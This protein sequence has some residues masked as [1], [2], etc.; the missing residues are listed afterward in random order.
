MGH[1]RSK[2]D[3]IVQ[4]GRHWTVAGAGVAGL[5]RRDPPNQ[6]V[7]HNMRRS[8]VPARG[9]T[10]NGHNRLRVIGESGHP[11]QSLI[12]PPSPFCP[13]KCIEDLL[14]GRRWWPRVEKLAIKRN[15]VRYACEMSAGRRGVAGGHPSSG[16]CLHKSHRGQTTPQQ[17]GHN[18]GLM[19]GQRLRRRP[20][21][22]P[23]LSRVCPSPIPHSRPWPWPV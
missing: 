16:R 4:A 13:R 19:L 15:L 3:E 9:P 23:A 2:G 1:V 21:I 12:T 11:V 6:R 22:K 10:L 18:A 7:R 17:T 14:S 20:N 5:P 8:C